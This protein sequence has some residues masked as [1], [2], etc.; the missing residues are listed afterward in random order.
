MKRY[1]LPADYGSLPSNSPPF[2]LGDRATVRSKPVSLPIEPDPGLP[3]YRPR[4]T[5][6]LRR[7]EEE[8]PESER[9]AAMALEGIWVASPWPDDCRSMD[10]MWSDRE[11]DSL[12]RRYHRHSLFVLLSLIDVHRNHGDPALL[13]CGADLVRSW[14][15]HNSCEAPPSTH[16]WHDHATAQRTINFCSFLDYAREHAPKP[17]SLDPGL[18]DLAVKALVQHAEFLADRRN[19]RF[20]HNHGLWQDYALLVAATHLEGVSSCESWIHL[21]YQRLNEQV[22][23][24]F[25]EEGVHLENSP[26]YQKWIARLFQRIHTYTEAV[27]LAAPA[28]LTDLVAQSLRVLDTIV[29]PDGCLPPVGDTKRGLKHARRSRFP[30]T[31]DI[32]NVCVYPE[33][34]YCVMRRGIYVFFNA[35]SYLDGHNHRDDL[36][37]IVA[38]NEGPLITDPGLLNYERECVQRAYTYSRAAHST[39]TARSEDHAMPARA[40][41]LDTFGN[42]ENWTF[43]RG[44]SR[45][46]GGIEHT[47]SLLHDSERG[48]LLVIDHC[49]APEACHWER[50]FL[51]EN[52]LRIVVHGGRM[53]RGQG[54]EGRSISVGLWPNSEEPRVVH[55][56]EEPLRGWVAR[57]HQELVPASGTIET[58]RGQAV[59]FAALIVTDST[60]LTVMRHSSGRY[61]YEV[62]GE[63]WMVSIGSREVR[64]LHASPSSRIIGIP[65]SRIEP[66]LSEKGLRREKQR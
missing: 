3:S 38:D 25:S 46:D 14:I 58:A 28:R 39:V 47:R 32:D 19:Y 30:E 35:S 4:Q 40:L 57:A 18:E 17:G 6:A 51:F 1:R 26:A 55:G 43:I 56:Q 59:S 15:A 61:R 33:A 63:T 2:L 65:L 45:R 5:C 9:A 48:H 49:R 54:Q 12:A 52:D 36:S 8:S 27:G 24:A 22:R 31:E 62:N 42:S 13:Q 11:I 41:C 23:V 7:V 34:G 53:I 60:P 50:H 44:R 64:V 66:G 29:M 21:A 37:I 10:A 20:A 16:S